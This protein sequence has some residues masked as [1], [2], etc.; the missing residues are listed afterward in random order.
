M[1]EALV[2]ASQN[3]SVYGCM[4]ARGSQEVPY[5]T[6]GQFTVCS[7]FV[8]PVLTKP[9]FYALRCVAILSGLTS[10]TPTASQSLL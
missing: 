4:T 1:P 6:Q 8:Q 5:G 3:T 7:L 2:R 10:H 9:W